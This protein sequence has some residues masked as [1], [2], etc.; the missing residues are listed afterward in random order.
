MPFRG[1]GGRQIG[2]EH[3]ILMFL[4]R[5]AINLAQLAFKNE[6]ELYK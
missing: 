3:T 4:L 2:E 6:V 1:G 5:G